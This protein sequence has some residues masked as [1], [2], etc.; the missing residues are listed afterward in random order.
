LYREEFRIFYLYRCGNASYTIQT[1]PAVRCAKFTNL[2]TQ[3]H[4]RVAPVV[5]QQEIEPKHVYLISVETW[6]LNRLKGIY[7]DGRAESFTIRQQAK[8]HSTLDAALSTPPPVQHPRPL[9]PRSPPRCCLVMPEHG[10]HHR[11]R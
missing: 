8:V 6:H 4:Y 2:P 7:H 1:C 11:E 10:I 3:A 5:K 9:Y